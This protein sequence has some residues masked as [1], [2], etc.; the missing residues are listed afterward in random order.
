MTPGLRYLG[1]VLH[2]PLIIYLWNKYYSLFWGVRFLLVMI[3]FLL[4]S[5]QVW[6]QTSRFTD[7]TNQRAGFLVESC[8]IC[9]YLL[10]AT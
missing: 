1:L 3:C 5:C 9:I 6:Y 2:F 7:L 4:G 8:D 10:E